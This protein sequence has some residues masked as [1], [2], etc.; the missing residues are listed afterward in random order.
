MRSR[1]WVAGLLAAGMIAVVQAQPGMFGF[2]GGGPSF[3][4]INKAV[5]EE[6]KM[7]EEQ[8]SKINE[9]SKEF[10]RTAMEIRKEHGVEFK[11]GGK[12]GFGFGKL[13]DEDKAKLE[14]ANAAIAQEAYK[15]LGDILNKDQITRLKQ[16]ERQML[17]VTA[18]T[19]QEIV[20]A[21]K[22]TDSQKA[23]V[24]GVIS[25]FQA[26]RREL[27]ADLGF[28]KGG[29]GKGKFDPEAFKEMAKRFQEVQTKVNK[30]EEEAINKILDV[31]DDNQKKTWKELV[32]APFD[33]SRMFQ[34]GFG[35]G[36]FG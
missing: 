11:F 7:T 5:Q 31:L 32:G 35:F 4:V 3:L 8:I 24:K 30:A 2:G 28:G 10:F 21:L 33:R 13:S 23:T 36:D 9:W 26:E 34:G 16:L 15:Q 14:K 1:Y 18:F 6:L 29:G 20:D 12:G 27:M 25:D 19:T 22:L 17:G